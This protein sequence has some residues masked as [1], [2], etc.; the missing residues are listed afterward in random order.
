MDNT[1]GERRRGRRPNHNDQDLERTGATLR[2]LRIDRDITQS[3]L[4]TALGFRYSTSVAQIE[5]GVKPLTDG[6]L[7]LAARFLDVK[8]LAIRRPEVTE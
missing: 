5:M 3:E 8:P 2:Q 4:A 1:T 6:K 7:L